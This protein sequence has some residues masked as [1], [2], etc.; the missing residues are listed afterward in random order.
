MP[1]DFRAVWMELQGDLAAL[2]SRGKLIVIGES[3]GD[4]IYQAPDA[5]VDAARQALAQFRGQ[6]EI[7]R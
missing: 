6:P 4:P 1:P 5:V 2:S 3:N 7:P